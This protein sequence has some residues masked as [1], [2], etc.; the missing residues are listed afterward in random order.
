ME[1]L[2]I[3]ATTAEAVAQL[4]AAHYWLSTLQASSCTSAGL[5]G[6]LPAT[7][8]WCGI[9]D[10]SAGKQFFQRLPLTSRRAE[11]APE[12]LAPQILLHCNVRPWTGLRRS[13][14]HVFLYT[15]WTQRKELAIQGAV[16]CGN[17]LQ[18]H[19]TRKRDTGHRVQSQQRHP[20]SS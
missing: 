9:K 8:C 12:F 4:R 1:R 11:L 5:T 16:C 13:G 19:S 6:N 20:M 2:Q 17:V 18:F 15:G 10:P 14:L 3:R 7:P